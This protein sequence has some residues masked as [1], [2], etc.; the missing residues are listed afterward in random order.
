MRPFQDAVIPEILAGKHLI[1]IAPTAGGKTEAAFFPVVSRM[2]E[3]GW[4][5]LSVL[6]ICPIKALLNN[7]DVRLQRY[8][9]LVRKAV[10]ALA[11]GRKDGGAQTNSERSSGL[12]AH[13]PG[14]DRGDT[15]VVDHQCT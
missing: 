10:G 13:D 12:P 8:C 1:I 7:L 11:W 9:S 2:L 4:S 3:E 14:V 6:Y 5:G 15:S